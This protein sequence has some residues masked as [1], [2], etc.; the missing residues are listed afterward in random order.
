M[1]K[2]IL[3]TLILLLVFKALTS[4]VEKYAADYFIPPLDG[5][6]YLSGTFGELRSN[7][8]H[9]GIDI[10]TG[11]A[12]GKNI[13]A[14]A[15]GYVSR[16]K[17]STGG[18]G[19]VVYITHPN[20]FVSVYGHLQKFNTPLKEYVEEL[21]YRREKFVVEG[22]PKKGEIEVRQGDIIAWSGNTG[23]ST[24]PHLHFEIREEASQHPVNPLLFESIA[25]KD[26]YRPKILGLAI[27]PV[28][29]NASINGK[30]DTVFYSVGGW[31]EDHYLQGKPEIELSGKVSFGV[32]AYDPMNDIANKNGVY[33]ID[34]YEDTIQI[35]GLEM[36]KISFAT[37]RYLN[38]L[39]DYG[40]FKKAKSRLVRTQ[41][42]TNNRLF[43]YRDV[44]ENGIIQFSDNAVHQMKYV[45]KD[46]Y[47]NTSVLKFKVKS[48]N[49]T[50][51]RAV[52]QKDDKDGRFFKFSV[53]NTVE[54]EDLKLNFPPQSFY[55]SFNFEFNTSTGDSTLFSPVF[56][57]HNV[58]T[59][60]HK[61]FTIKIKPQEI[62]E[63]YKDKLYISYLADNG[64]HW[65]IGAKW[66]NE[67][68]VAKS[69]LFGN[70]AVMMD[71]IKPEITP[72]NIFDGKDVKAQKSIK[73]KVRDRETG[74]SRY[75]GEIN[76]KWV[77]FEYEPKK[78]RLEYKID[79]HLIIGENQL[80]IRVVDLLG[81]ESVYE[82]MLI[83]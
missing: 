39:I 31:G 28:D 55:Q 52:T 33:T 15:D 18:Y 78:S 30:N 71:S 24:A 16:I 53:N 27:Y 14:I 69:K 26:F 4:Q 22:Y 12:E 79:D 47:G 45:I 59:P 82:A 43:N 72:T 81:N 74:I 61:S 51:K 68:L 17:V 3:V 23:G 50:L 49:D 38:S 42:D 19:K 7:H 6:L 5:Q 57:I 41:I 83:Y 25:V 9:A 65:Y 29:D 36:N 35:F 34:F 80:E 1:T 77:L 44:L 56:H 32:R 66:D 73:I 20:G 58:F 46:L 10:K 13:Y 2:N 54:N 40:H 60:V 21:Q 37:T 48:L 67:W 70:Y 62:P 76:G 64:G 63:Q 8:F 75:R 11:G